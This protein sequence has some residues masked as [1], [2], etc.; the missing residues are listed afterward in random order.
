MAAVHAAATTHGMCV[1]VPGTCEQSLDNEKLDGELGFVDTIE[2]LEFVDAS[3]G[4]VGDGDSEFRFI[5]SASNMDIQTRPRS[6]ADLFRAMVDSGANVSLGPKRLA[7][8]LGC[9]IIPHTDGRKIGTADSEGSMEILGWIFPRGFTGPIA[10]VRKAAW[11]L[12]SV[13]EL[14]SRGIGVNFPPESKRCDLYLTQGSRHHVFLEVP[15]HPS[16]NLFYIDIRKLMTGYTPELASASEDV[17]ADILSS[18][19]GVIKASVKPVV[20]PQQ[21]EPSKHK[22]RPT[23][24][25]KFR[26]WTL[27]QD[28]NHTS[29]SKIAYMVDHNKLRNATCTKEEILTVRD[30]QDCYSCLIAKGRALSKGPLTGI[31]PSIFGQRWS[32]DYQ[33][34]NKVPAIGAW[35]GRYLFVEMSRGYPE[36]VL[37]KS[38]SAQAAFEAVQKVFLHCAMYGHHMQYLQV[39]AGSTENALEFKTLCDMINDKHGTRGIEINAVPINMQ[40]R[41]T[42]ERYQQTFENTYAAIMVDNDL[43]PA[44]FWGLGVLATCDTLKKITN[45]L[46]DDGNGPDYY[47]TGRTT[48]LAHHFRVGFGKPVVCTR[49]TKA[50]GP[51]LPGIPRNEFGICVGPGG[52]NGAILVYLPERGTHAVSLRYHVRKIRIASTRQE[53]I[54]DGKKYLPTLGD[55]GAWHLVTKGDSAQGCKRF[56]ALSEED[57]GGPVDSELA[58]FRTRDLTSS[59]D[60]DILM[61]RMNELSHQPVPS[62]EEQFADVHQARYMTRMMSLYNSR[63]SQEGSRRPS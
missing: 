55:D 40:E 44:P 47:F 29:L 38:K 25:M 6:V 17:I 7:K 45:S 32:M 20:T 2:D 11:T 1:Q 16:Q 9:A 41:N 33:G 19:P 52:P 48:D 30:H 4:L 22:N 27:H 54:E 43:L 46:C 56:A 60:T 61:L 51:K 42:V 14:Q 63:R 18:C 31:R 58:E 13:G 8:A 12:L 34:P 50:S 57:L 5:I 49:V 59:V 21:G 26:V 23:L 39:D 53:S 3:Q 35:T 28:M 15:L 36:V 10:I 62:V 37:T 24:D